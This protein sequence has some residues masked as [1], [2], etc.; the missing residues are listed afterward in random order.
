MS[1]RQAL[2]GTMT[3]GKRASLTQRL[4]LGLPQLR[5]SPRLLNTRTRLLSQVKGNSRTAESAQGSVSDQMGDG[6]ACGLGGYDA[7]QVALGPQHEADSA[8]E[9]R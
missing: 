2:L 3:R 6:E 4:S 8:S 1:G 9:P 7:G 5:G